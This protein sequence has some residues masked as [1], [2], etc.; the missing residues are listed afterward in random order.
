MT[1]HE[2]SS[3]ERIIRLTVDMP[4]SMHRALSVRAAQLGKKKAEIIRELVD[5]YLQAVQD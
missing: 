1:D 5:V 4:E 2:A 3:K